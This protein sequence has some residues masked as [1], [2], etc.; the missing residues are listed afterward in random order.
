LGAVSFAFSLTLDWQ[1]TVI[2]SSI[3]Q[4]SVGGGVGSTTTAWT[5][6]I[7]SYDAMGLA[8]LLGVIAMLG[9]VGAVVTRPGLAV[10]WGGLAGGATAGLTAMLISMTLRMK[11]DVLFGQGALN[12]L[13]AGLFAG[14]RQAFISSYEPG[15]YF[16]FGAVLLPMLAILLAVVGRSR[17]E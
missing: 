12:S 17:P 14:P 10:R 9:L 15:L 11:S 8:Y 3:Y 13:Y 7:A 2:D 5:A 1:K 16:G 4:R 6:G